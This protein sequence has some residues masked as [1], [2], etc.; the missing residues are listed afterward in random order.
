MSL[1]KILIT[2]AG[3]Q[4][5]KAL[6]AKIPSGYQAIAANRETLDITT[7]SDV[8]EF[9]DGL[10][11]SGVINAAAYTAVDKAESQA[12]AAT[13]VNVQGVSNLGLAAREHDLPMIHVSTDFVFDG[14]KGTPYLP[15]DK[16]EPKSVYGQSKADGEDALLTIDGLQSTIIR[17]AWVYNLSLIHI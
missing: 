14:S 12:D 15:H 13:A 7:Q 8:F 11:L 3:G 4:L 16:R 17:T 9:F 10:E 2:G 6:L 1:K 5:G